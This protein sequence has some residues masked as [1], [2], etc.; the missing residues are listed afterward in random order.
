MSVPRQVVD[1]MISCVCGCECLADEQVQMKA[2]RTLQTAV[3]SEPSYVHGASLLLCVRT[4]C[5]VF[6]GSHS[7]P[8]QTAAKGALSQMMSAMMKRMEAASAAV[9]DTQSSSK[10]PEGAEELQTMEQR[11]VFEVFSRLCKLSMKFDLVDSWVKS[12]EAMNM[13]SKV[14]ALEL[15]L[16]M[17]NQCG[18]SLRNS[19]QFVACIRQNLCMSLLKNG[20]SSVQRVFKASLQVFSTLMLHFK[21]H[22]K[23]EIGVFFTTIFLRILESPNSTFYQKIMVIQLLHNMCKDPQ[24]MVDIYVNYDCDLKHIDIFA[25]MLNQLTRIVQSGIQ[26]APASTPI[27][28]E[29]D[30]QLRSRGTEALVALLESLL[31][32]S[33]VVGKDVVFLDNGEMVPRSLVAEDSASGEANGGTPLQR[34]RSPRSRDD[35]ENGDIGIEALVIKQKEQKTQLQQGI[36]AFNIKPKK[37]LELLVQGGHVEKSHEGVASF[38]H[39][40]PVLDKKAVGEYMGEGDD[41]NKGVLYAYVDAMCFEGMTI[42]GALRHFLSGF[43]LPGGR[44]RRSIG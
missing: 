23:Q 12:D 31:R 29:Q 6:L 20:V 32:W 41:F 19:A 15:L 44:R 22:L 18:P 8:N 26:Y 40:T 24:T 28:P 3:M 2:V 4:C 21:T 39:N 35:G 13:Q 38:F 9:P 36:K 16:E 17:L 7:T 34:N 37:G 11:D 27:T 43:W 33:K 25:K 42:D 1:V 10:I 30:Q 14:L 5:N